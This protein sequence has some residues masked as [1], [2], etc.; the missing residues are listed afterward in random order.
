MSIVGTIDSTSAPVR[1][2]PRQR[3]VMADPH[4]EQAIALAQAARLPL[5]LAE[6]LIARG[7]TSGPEAHAF[8]PDVSQPTSLC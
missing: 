1:K 3:W 7:V 5:V 4:P 6:L 8:E 2:F